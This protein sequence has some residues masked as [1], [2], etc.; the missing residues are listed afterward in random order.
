LTVQPPYM[1]QFFDIH[2]FL[3][4]LMIALHI[5]IITTCHKLL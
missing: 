3:L 5:G 2:D 1:G 4:F